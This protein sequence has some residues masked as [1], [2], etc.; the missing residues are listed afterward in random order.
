MPLV[1]SGIGVSQ[2]DNLIEAA[3]EAAQQAKKELG[4]G[5]IPKILMFFCIFTYPVKDYKKAIETVYNVF[6]DKNIPLV[7]GSVMGF[8]AK[9]KYYFDIRLAGNVVGFVMQGLGKILKPFKFNG[10]SV[11]ALSSDYLSIG[12]GIGLDVD[13]NPEEAGKN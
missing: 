8:F 3:K 13:K 1:Y 6:G 2:K 11:V 9:D 7:G 10:V 12:A 5:K 4:E